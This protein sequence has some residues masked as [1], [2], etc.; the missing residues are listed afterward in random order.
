MEKRAEEFKV[1]ELNNSNVRSNFDA[2]YD[3]FHQPLTDIISNEGHM[4]G[5]NKK[6]ELKGFEHTT[7]TRHIETELSTYAK[8]WNSEL[9]DLKLVQCYN[10]CKDKLNDTLRYILSFYEVLT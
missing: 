4:I 1:N 7:E 6:G 8:S 3:S 9:L 5:I 2:L 10:E